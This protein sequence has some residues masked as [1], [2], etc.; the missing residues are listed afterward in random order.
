MNAGIWVFIEQKSGIFEEASLKVLSEGRK[1]ADKTKEELSAVLFG[2]AVRERATELA[3]Y[4]ADRVLLADRDVLAKYH[5]ELY[6]RMLSNLVEEFAPAVL[7]YAATSTGMDLAPKVAARTKTGVV[8]NCDGIDI[9]DQK[10]LIATKPVFAAKLSK[11]AVCPEKRPQMATLLP[12]VLDYGKVNK[13]RVCEIVE[14]SGEFH[15]QEVSTKIKGFIKGDPKTVDIADA[16][17]IVAVG[18]GLGDK[19]NLKMVEEL[20]DTIGA[21]IGG[22]RVVVDNGWLPF[23]RQI[24]QTGKT[25]VPKLIV[26]VGISGAIQ[27]TMGMK[28]AKLIIANNKDK[29]AA[30]FKVADFG[31]VGDYRDWIPVLNEKLRQYLAS[32]ESEG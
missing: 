30:I 31:L 10:E 28:N 3:Y 26:T 6:V 14:V 17:M 24:G 15:L 21:S 7:L 23:P 32:I 29:D 9:N 19:E 22:S 4:G 25:V 2:E 5:P 11:K 8:T 20:A 27:F 12:E 16:D 13:S 18:G 1:L